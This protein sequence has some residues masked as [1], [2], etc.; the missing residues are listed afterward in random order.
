MASIAFVLYRVKDVFGYAIVAVSPSTLT[1]RSV[2]LGFVTSL[3]EFDNNLVRNL[4]YEEWS[5]GRAGQQNDIRFE[6][7]SKTV[8]FARQ[9]SQEDSWALIDR[10]CEIF[11]FSVPAP[12]RSPAVI[13]WSE[14]SS[15]TR[16][17]Q[18]RY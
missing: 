9:A 14:Q 3:K 2:V 12:A 5:G 15:D 4:R 7:D 11:K 8:T 16:G 17:E 10:L 1:V 18:M 13:D 6:Y